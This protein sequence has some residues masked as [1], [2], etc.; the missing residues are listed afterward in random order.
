MHIVRI[1]IRRAPPKKPIRGEVIIGSTTLGQSPVAA[2]LASVAA[3][4]S[5]FQFPSA[6]ASA[7][8]HRP[9]MSAW[10]ELDGKPSHHV[11]RFHTMAPVSPAKIVAMVT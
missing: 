10:L 7:A 3:Q 8:P 9:P 11:A 2:P 6:E 1:N 4:R 5:T